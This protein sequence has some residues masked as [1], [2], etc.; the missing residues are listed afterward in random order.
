M[1][2]PPVVADPSA[3]MANDPLALELGICPGAGLTGQDD[4]ASGVRHISGASPTA[5]TSTDVFVADVSPA[6]WT[7]KVGFCPVVATVS[8]VRSMTR[9]ATGSKATSTQPG[10][11]LPEE[12][13]MVNFADVYPEAAGASNL[14]DRHSRT[15]D[16]GEAQAIRGTATS[17]GMTTLLGGVVHPSVAVRASY[18]LMALL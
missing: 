2:P 3:S 16:P 17:A 15:P 9:L 6:Y 7:M 5:T 12:S 14:I 8:E 11:A 1:V 4:T 10:I 13:R 18:A